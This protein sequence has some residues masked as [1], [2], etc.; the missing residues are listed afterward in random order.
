[1]DRESDY[2]ADGASNHYPC[3]RVFDEECGYKARYQAEWDD[4]HENGTL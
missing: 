3:E 2:R 4:R 1:M